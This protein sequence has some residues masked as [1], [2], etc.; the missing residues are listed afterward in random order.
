[1]PTYVLT[2]QINTHAL[3]SFARI[4]VIVYFDS[5]ILVDWHVSFKLLTFISDD[6]TNNRNDFVLRQPYY[7]YSITSSEHVFQYCWFTDGMLQLEFT[8]LFSYISST[9]TIMYTKWFFYQ[10]ISMPIKQFN[11]HNAYHG[12]HDKYYLLN[13]IRFS[14]AHQV[15]C[16]YIG[17]NRTV[18]CERPSINW[19]PLPQ[20]KNWKMI[21]ANEFSIILIF[22]SPS[23]LQVGYVCW[24]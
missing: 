23:L 7:K 21:L 15:K 3:L 19:M 2:Y 6:N 10:W 17:A 24:W 4:Y 9:C 5:W 1:M 8:W 11:F 18:A 16:R 13:E 14:W 12:G 22:V 20:Q